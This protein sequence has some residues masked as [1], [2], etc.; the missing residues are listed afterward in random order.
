MKMQF[1]V[2]FGSILAN[3]SRVCSFMSQ[4]KFVLFKYQEAVVIRRE[5][6]D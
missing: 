6:I 3:S 4:C 2:K 5:N 1:S